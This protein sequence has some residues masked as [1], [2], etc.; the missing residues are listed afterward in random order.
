MNGKLEAVITVSLALTFARPAK[1]TWEDAALAA[2]GKVSVFGDTDV[3]VTAII[4]PHV[5]SIEVKE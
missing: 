5:D 2:F 3:T 1:G 4:E